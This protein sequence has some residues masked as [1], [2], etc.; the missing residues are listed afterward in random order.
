MKKITSILI[1]LVLMQAPSWAASIIWEAPSIITADT[2]VSTQGN[3]V[4][5][6][7]F[8]LNQSGSVALNGVAF[9]SYQR[10][11]SPS[12]FTVGT[13]EGTLALPALSSWAGYNPY[14][15]GAGSGDFINLSASYQTLL[16]GGLTTTAGVPSTTYTFTNLNIGQTYLVQ[17]WLND[18]RGT[19]GTVG[20]NNTLTAGN[21]VMLDVNVSNTTGGLGQYVIG[22][23]IA[24]ASIQSISVVPGFVSPSTT[25]DLYLNAFQIRAIPEPSSMVLLI[26]S[27]VSFC[28]MRRRC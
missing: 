23:F 6:W 21:S 27:L 2:D 18:S 11:Q 16:G 5:A 15:F 13:G 1:V 20:R 7:R 22:T 26:L 25:A 4:Q 28:A 10:N 9:S 8:S 3:L 17:F 24:D 19:T 14:T 12:A